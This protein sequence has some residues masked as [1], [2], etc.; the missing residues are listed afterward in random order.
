MSWYGNDAMW[1]IRF[2]RDARA[3]HGRRLSI[4]LTSGVRTYRLSGLEVPGRDDVPVRIEFY[5]CAP[6]YTFGLKPQDYPR[7]FA[8]PG[9][10]SEH[11]L[12][13]D[14]LCLYAPF[15]RE[16]RRWT[17]KHGLAQLLNLV[18]DHLFCE[19]VWQEKRVWPADAAP[20]RAPARRAA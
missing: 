14:A 15:D 8:D 18:R 7:V 6:Y 4:Q 1:F 2:D 12:R 10:D 3:Q 17:S 9:A 13:D 16:E 11:R 19:M 5:A 20:H